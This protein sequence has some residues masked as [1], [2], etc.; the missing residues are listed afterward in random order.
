[1]PLHDEAHIFLNTFK[2]KKKVS[3]LG[4]VVIATAVCRIWKERN[5]RIF[6]AS[7]IEQNASLQEAL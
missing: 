6:S 1:M 2:G 7:R 4:K 5:S 3:A